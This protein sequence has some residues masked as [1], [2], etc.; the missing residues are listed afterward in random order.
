M[1]TLVAMKKWGLAVFAVVLLSISLLGQSDEKQIKTALYEYSLALKAKDWDKV[2]EMTYPPLFEYAPRDQM[3]A[4]FIQMDNDLMKVTFKEVNP[5]ALSDIFVFEESK[6][7]IISYGMKIKLELIGTVWTPQMIEII[8]DQLKSDG[9][10]VIYQENESVIL[11]EG[12][13]QM[14]AIKELNNSDSWTFIEK[15]EAQE[16]FVE[17]LLPEEVLQRFN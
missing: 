6:Y 3:K 12:D 11:L 10:K 4:A 8:T 14:F 9:S 7:A 15:N 13:K 5:T 17:N 16:S 2:F 1:A